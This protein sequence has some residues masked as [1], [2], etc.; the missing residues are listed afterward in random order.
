MVTEVVDGPLAFAKDNPTFGQI[1]WRQFN[2]NFVPGDD[3]NEVLSHFSCDVRHHLMAVFKF[4]TKLRVRK[5][6]HNASFHL[7]C[8]FLW[9]YELYS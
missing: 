5:R 4:D 7:D 3:S 9:H 2:T 6:L 8:F 1:V